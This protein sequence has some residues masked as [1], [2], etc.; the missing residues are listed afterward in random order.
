MVSKLKVFYQRHKKAAPVIFFFGGF[1]WDSLTLQRID[2]LYSNVVLFGYLLCLMIALY[3]YNVS[4]DGRWK[5]TFLESYQDYAPL[6]V[7]FFLG[8]LSSAYVIFFFR[9]VSLTQTMVFF[10]LLVFLLVSNEFLKHRISNKYLQFGAFF[11]VTFTFMEFMIP[12]FV[13]VISTFWFIVSGL[14]ALGITA[15]FIGFI[16]RRSPSTRREINPVPLASIIAAIYLTINVLYYFNMI[17]PVPMALQQGIIAYDVEKTDHHYAVTY[18]PDKR[19]KMWRI[20]NHEF[21]YTPGD[22]VFAYTSIFAPTNLT[23]EVAHRW[24]WLDPK[25]DTWQIS[26]EISYEVE[27]GRGGG[28]RGYT[29]K[30][31]IH[32]GQWEIDVITSE[33]LILGTINFEVHRDATPGQQQL[34]REEF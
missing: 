6:A 33:G 32:P 14:V 4:D 26:D 2:H 13:G 24:K 7:Q 8:G 16:Y 3:I 30:T 27:G 21:S 18:D 20:F 34:V 5:N 10:I 12:V 19:Y 29:F 28:Y 31:N 25:T 23:E 11:F 17:P 22:T 1:I 15:A 9:S